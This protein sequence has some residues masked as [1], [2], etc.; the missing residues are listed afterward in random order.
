MVKALGSRV[1]L[2]DECTSEIAA[3]FYLAVGE[4]IE[5]DAVR[6]LDEVNQHMDTTRFQHS[7]NVSYYSFRLA[8]K[9]GLDARAAARGG[10]LHDLF[11]YDTSAMHLGPLH[12][13]FHP[14]EALRNAEKLTDLTDTERD[15]IAAHMWPMTPE[16]PKYKESYL[17]TFV[18]KW[19]ASFEFADYVA[20]R[21]LEKGKL[22]FRR[23]AI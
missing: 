13:S 20:R 2:G 12:W 8:L 21:A 23:S 18:D 6:A 16:R 10:L 17:V 14:Q 1:P 3:A 9:F 11:Y 19:C 15:I 4:L 7:L 5:S 22:V